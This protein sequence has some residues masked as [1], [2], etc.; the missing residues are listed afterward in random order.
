D[1][2]GFLASAG[3]GTDNRAFTSV[4]YGGKAGDD[5]YYRVYG[6]FMDHADSPLP[7]GDPA[8]D[9]WQMG[10]SGFRM[11]WN[12]SEDNLL[13]FQGEAYLGKFNQ[14]FTMVDPTNP[15]SFS[16]TEPDV[17]DVRGANLLGRWTHCFSDTS[18]LKVLCFY[19]RNERESVIIH[20]KNDTA[21]LDIQHSFALGER[22][23]V[24]WGG[25]YRFTHDD[26]RGSPTVSFNP[27]SSS[28]DLFNAYV[29][30]EIALIVD[31]LHFMFGSKFEHNDF[32]GFEFEPGVRLL[33]TPDDQNTVWA[34]IARAVRTPCRA[35]QD[36]T[37]N[38]PVPGGFVTTFGNP[39]SQSEELIA[40][41]LGYRVR[42]RKNLSF[43][44]AG[45][46]NVYDKLR[47]AELVNFSPPQLQIDSTLFGE[48]YG[49]EASATWDVTPWW[50]LQPAYTFLEMQLRTRPGSTD[51]VTA[52][53]V[54]GQSPE[55]QCSLRSSLDLPHNLSLDGTLRYVDRLP[56]FQI[57][58][59]VTLDVRLGWRPTKNLELA[60]VGQDLLEPR[61]AEFHPT[62]IQTQA[63]QVPRS[64]YGKL[65][66]HF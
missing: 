32:T 60:L 57:D 18:E 33:W 42:P 31:R 20:E 44:F 65:T 29:Q 46:Y 62:T 22:N 66:W 52:S 13:T 58:S 12:A 9:A 25:G 35:D 24:V 27:S 16:Q 14:T 63:T 15:P 38:R 50:R 6:T 28:K 51:T 64:F 37:Y 41:E 54:E 5:A 17:M 34:S 11:D 43:D 48:T 40:Y 49:F 30:D 39:N 8:N 19:D 55:Q 45:F 1:T 10:R 3:G 56:S 47:D 23:H 36:V 26:L 4:R 53:M 7:N 21:D 59:Y 61:H 2:Q